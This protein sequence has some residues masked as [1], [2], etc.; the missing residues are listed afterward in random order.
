MGRAEWEGGRG[1]QRPRNAKK[2]APRGGFTCIRYSDFDTSIASSAFVDA[3]GRFFHTELIVA[4]VGGYSFSGGHEAMVIGMHESRCQRVVSFRP[5]PKPT[6]PSTKSASSRRAM[7]FRPV[8]KRKSI[9]SSSNTGRRTM[10]F[11]SVPKPIHLVSAHG[12]AFRSRTARKNRLRASTTPHRKASYKSPRA[13]IP[14]L[15]AVLA[16]ILPW[17]RP[18]RRPLFTDEWLSPPEI[19]P[20]QKQAV[21]RIPSPPG[22]F[23]IGP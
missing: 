9:W 8:L 4:E 12:L 23:G 17:A 15:A 22:L 7:P 21:S 20:S 19:R 10:A 6:P 18:R 2:A 16:A 11:R 3:R 13:S 1:F 14:A 5:V